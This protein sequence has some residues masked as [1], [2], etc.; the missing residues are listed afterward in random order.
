MS[1]HQDLETLSRCDHLIRSVG[2]YSWWAAFKLQGRRRG[3]GGKPF[4]VYQREFATRKLREEFSK[5]A[6]DY[7]LPGWIAL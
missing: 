5:E 4:V 2:T 3:H 1:P 7:H 6:E